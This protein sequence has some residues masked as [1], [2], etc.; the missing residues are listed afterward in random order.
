MLQRLHRDVG[1]TVL[2]SSHVLSEVEK[3]ITH[4]GVMSRVRLVRQGPL[5]ALASRA[6]AAS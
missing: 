6:L 5:E 4:V 2:I 3:L 1:V